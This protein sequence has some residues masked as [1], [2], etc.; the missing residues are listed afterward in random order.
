MIGD[1]S[2]GILHGYVK[3]T[4]DLPYIYVN[5]ENNISRG[6]KGNVERPLLT[7]QIV[8]ARCSA[9][10]R[11]GEQAI[12]GNIAL[13]RA[14]LRTAR[15][16]SVADVDVAGAA[17]NIQDAA[18]AVH[19]NVAHGSL[20]VEQHRGSIG[21]EDALRQGNGY[22]GGIAIGVQQA[23]AIGERHIHR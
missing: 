19:R 14:Q 1:A 21:G 20:D 13:R 10:G 9:I 7:G 8:P 3:V 23:I 11:N 4:I 17:A 6:R 18:N 2:I 5:V 16:Q 15:Q 12:E 22:I